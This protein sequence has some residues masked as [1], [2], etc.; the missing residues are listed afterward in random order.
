MEFWQPILN[1]YH[2]GA[3]SLPY[4]I[5]LTEADFTELQKELT[6]YISLPAGN[7]DNSVLTDKRQ[8]ITDLLAL[9]KEER[10]ELSVLLAGY[11][12]PTAHYTPF[13]IQVISAACMGSSHLWSDLGL[14]Q[15]DRLGKMIEH[16]FPTLHAKNNNNMRWKR[17][18]Y[19]QLCEQGGDFVCRAPSCETCSSFKECFY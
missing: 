8:L 7:N 9:R 6:Y 11:Q 13:A 16:Y 2:S 5:G 10:N 3:T 1:S 15:R 4:F 17:F 18:F 14:P 12:N 19:K